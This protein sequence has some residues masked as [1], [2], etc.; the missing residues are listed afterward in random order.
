MSIFGDIA[1][2]IGADKAEDKQ[3]A[4]SQA[5]LAEQRKAYEDAK[6]G[7]SPYTQMGTDSTAL[8]SRLFGLGGQPADMSAFTASP[9]YKFRLQQGEDAI[10]R[11]AAA[12]GGLF[13]GAAGKALNDYAQNT[14]SQEFDNYLNRL[15][16]MSG[17]GQTAATN[18]GSM[19]MGNGANLANLQSGIGENQANRV[20]NQYNALGSMA[21]QGAAAV[22]GGMFGIPGV[23][24]GTGGAG[25]RAAIPGGAQ[26]F[27]SG[28]FG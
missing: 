18:L 7:L 26:G 25:A 22:M 2:F 12:T 15:F 27:L 24:G 3:Y 19:R 4:A 6:A 9:G 17:S 28:L 8:L 1:G 16:G 20:M 5:A 11:S 10:G 13:S 23:A 21:D 14:A